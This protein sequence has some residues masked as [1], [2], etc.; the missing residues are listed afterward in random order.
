MKKYI[1]TA[2]LAVFLLSGTAQA[3][4]SAT[5]FKDYVENGT[6]PASKKGMLKARLANGSVIDMARKANLARAAIALGTTVAAIYFEDEMNKSLYELFLDSTAAPQPELDDSGSPGYVYKAY[7]NNTGFAQTKRLACAPDIYV[8]SSTC[9][10]AQ[11]NAT[12]GFQTVDCRYNG[13]IAQCSL[14]PLEPAFDPLIDYPVYVRDGGVT[15][16]VVPATDMAFPDNRWMEQE[17][18]PDQLR[19]RVKV[20]I[21]PNGNTRITTQT[22]YLDENGNVR[23]KTDVVEMNA[24]GEVVSES[25]SDVEGGLDS[26][27]AEDAATGPEDINITNEFGL[28]ETQLKILEKLTYTDGTVDP[29]APEAM[30]V[31]FEQLKIDIESASPI[32]DEIPFYAYL[33]GIGGGGSC[34]GITTQSNSHF[35]SMTFNSHCSFITDYA[36]PALGFLFSVF[37][38]LYLFSLY[39]TETSRSF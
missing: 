34:H 10:S 20:E 31:P 7:I 14:P 13:H 25:S 19:Q 6:Q 21:L 29:L 9:K 1:Y 27:A 24:E 2:A 39:R 22:E 37:T 30:N 32:L 17:T 35:D 33:T 8:N 28:E 26:A 36:R 38:L 5:Q 12:G 18:A 16:G 23:T 3:F 4:D 11:Y 15:V